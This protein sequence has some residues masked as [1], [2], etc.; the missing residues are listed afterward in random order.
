[1]RTTG[2]PILL[3]TDQWH[4]TFWVIYQHKI[5]VTTQACLFIIAKNQ[6][7]IVR[8][9][10]WRHSTYISSQITGRPMSLTSKTDQHAQAAEQ[11][12]R[13]EIWDRTIRSKKYY[14]ASIRSI[15][16]KV[17]YF[18]FLMFINHPKLSWTVWGLNIYLF[19][20]TYWLNKILPYL[21]HLVTECIRNLD[22]T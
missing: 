16:G 11:G 12:K 7:R 3:M 8:S 18:L 9:H 14:R 10:W 6:N 5:L 15:E 20:F 19:T 2:L 13:Q 1:M 4:Q 22:A 17:K 21:L